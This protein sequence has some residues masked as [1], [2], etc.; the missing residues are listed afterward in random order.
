[1]TKTNTT[2]LSTALILALSACG[3][4]A[5]TSAITSA[6]N[7]NNP[8]NVATT[9]QGTTT[10]S[11]ATVCFDANN[12][13]VC[14]ADDVV[15][16]TE[17]DGSY[18]LTLK[19]APKNGEKLIVEDGYNLILE[20][21]NLKKFRFFA[22]YN[23]ALTEHNINTIT[24]ML[25]SGISLEEAK[26]S[27]AS[28]LNLDASL[29]LED[30]IEL[31]STDTSLLL[32]VHG[33]EDGYKTLYSS[34]AAKA[35][36]LEGD[37]YVT[38][39]V[40]A[41][42]EILADG[43]YL[44]FDVASFLTRLELKIKDLFYSFTNSIAS[45]FGNADEKSTFER[46]T[47]NGMWLN[48]DVDNQTKLCVAFSAD[49]LMT[50]Y[51]KG[52]EESAETISFYYSQPKESISLYEGWM[53]LAEL[54]VIPTEGSTDAFS[55]KLSTQ[56]ANATPLA[57]TR[58]SDLQSCQDA[59]YKVDGGDTNNTEP[60]EQEEKIILPTL[61]SFSGKIS[62]VLPEGIRAQN[63]K[64]YYQNPYRS[65]RLLNL[66][67]NGS[68][69]I[70]ALNND[71][72]VLIKEQTNTLLLTLETE[73][74][75]DNYTG[76][77]KTGAILEISADA[78]TNIDGNNTLNIGEYQTE[79]VEVNMCLNDFDGKP[80]E[81]D[82]IVLD[83]QFT[84]GEIENNEVTFFTP[85]DTKE[86]F[87][88][89][90]GKRDV[91][92]ANAVVRFHTDGGSLDLRDSC[93]N[94]HASSEDAVEITLSKPSDNNQSEVVLSQF[95]AESIPTTE[96]S[97]DEATGMRVQKYK[98]DM[99]DGYFFTINMYNNSEDKNYLVNKT[100]DVTI[101]DE[102][103]PLTLDFMGRDIVNLASL[104]VV[105]GDLAILRDVNGKVVKAIE[106]K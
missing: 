1:M 32:T 30:P 34:K 79:L 84:D 3:E 73:L 76:Y 15:S 93:V 4:D 104:L 69:N 48:N 29:L 88:A 35:P 45:I 22:P 86:H 59:I 2:L 8:V 6:T 39:T 24:S 78:M 40:D 60:E 18:S 77:R 82:A 71:S 70:L 99:F 25:E 58:Y 55:M 56:D 74:Y 5:T 41:S 105:D 13:S 97:I 54:Q 72:K 103:Y 90:L 38:P 57:F 16:Q 102:T 101:F 80:A 87:V 61:Q 47:L 95:L 23:D 50:T 91:T 63:T 20:E 67:E 66:D 92:L 17:A 33:I 43:S 100:V 68:F 94:L 9:I 53:Q 46:E 12:N 62:L 10:L 11:K 106:R 52:I 7:T 75:S 14:D 98:K 65:Y 81:L 42:T 36:A 96:N 51:I 21:S 85:R 64:V 83:T 89:F 27:L 44:D 31:A 37:G 19:S 28:A 26:A 49:D